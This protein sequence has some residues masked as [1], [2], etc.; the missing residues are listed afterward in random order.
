MS[1]KLIVNKDFCAEK[2]LQNILVPIVG[3][4]MSQSADIRLT[5]VT[6][7]DQTGSFDIEKSDK[8]LLHADHEL[9]SEPQL[10]SVTVAVAVA[11]EMG[12]SIQEIESGLKNIHPVNGRMQRLAG[13]N[14][15][16]II[17]DS[18]NASPEAMKAALNTLYRL[19]ASQKIAVLGNMNELGAYSQSEHE[20]IGRYCDPKQLSLVITLG[21]DANKFLAIAAKAKGC[22]AKTFNSPY[23]IGEYLK[24]IVNKDTL[25]LVKGSQNGVFAEEAVKIL[26]A[27]K[28]DEAKLVRQSEYW[29]KR[30]QKSFKT[31]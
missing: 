6:F 1:D 30:K 11:I 5:N 26:L 18:Y 16:V 21:P 28:A 8:T 9:V 24:T 20:E 7:S 25:V 27:D 31:T 14:G 23:E 13:I 15:S 2:Y 3:C 10:Y 29:L 22:M 4:A 12:L 19:N 17:D